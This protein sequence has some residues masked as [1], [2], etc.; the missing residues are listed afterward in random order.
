MSME[1]LGKARRKFKKMYDES[2]ENEDATLEILKLIKS[3]GRN[4]LDTYPSASVANEVEEQ[5]KA[6]E[7][8]IEEKEA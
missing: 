3:Y 5:L 7:E 6:L 2:I 8:R 4:M 1:K